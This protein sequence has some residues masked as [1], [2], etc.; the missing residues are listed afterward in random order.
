MDI[1]QIDRTNIKLIGTFVAAN[2]NSCNDLVAKF[3]G[4]L[5]HQEVNKQ[6]IKF[7]IKSDATI[8][9][10]VI[11]CQNNQ[12]TGITFSGI[13]DITF[14]DLV[15]LFG[16]GSEFYERYDDTIEFIFK[17]AVLDNYSVKCFILND[18]KKKN[19]WESEKL[20]NISIH[21]T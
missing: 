16:Q 9:S 5:S 14:T 11:D 17:D 6:W 10:V 18:E 15:A 20:G 2:Q 3:K 13:L 12:V 4:T 7:I 19:N 1:L 8:K 21:L